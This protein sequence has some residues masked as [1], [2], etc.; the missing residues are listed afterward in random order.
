VFQGQALERLDLGEYLI[1]WICERP[2]VGVVFLVDFLLRRDV[3]KYAASN[4]P[5][6]INDSADS[7]RRW[8]AGLDVRLVVPRGPRTRDNVGLVFGW[9][10]RQNLNR[11]GVR[12]PARI[13]PKQQVYALRQLCRVN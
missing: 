13:Q 10:K 8:Q 12:L 5:L 3:G 4:L 2:D 11:Q 6:N 7:L 1:R 9:G